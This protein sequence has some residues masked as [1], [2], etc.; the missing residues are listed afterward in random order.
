MGSWELSVLMGVA[1]AE[2]TAAIASETVTK[3]LKQEATK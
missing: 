2:C 3:M 1:N